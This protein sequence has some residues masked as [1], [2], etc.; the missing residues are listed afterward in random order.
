MIV[1][2]SLQTSAPTES[3]YSVPMNCLLRGSLTFLSTI[4]RRISHCG[5]FQTK[6]G[7]TRALL[8]TTGH[9]FQL[10]TIQVQCAFL[11]LSGSEWTSFHRYPISP[12]FDPSNLVGTI[13]FWRSALMMVRCTFTDAK[14]EA[15]QSYGM[16]LQSGH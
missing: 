13:N 5:E 15:G 14:P 10:A 11:K 9:C 4:I 16:R 2:C 3:S 6:A 1:R 8:A 7:S 12:V